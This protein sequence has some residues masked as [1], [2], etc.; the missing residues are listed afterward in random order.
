MKIEEISKEE[1][2]A[3]I[4]RAEHAV[5]HGLALEAE[6]VQLLIKALHSLLVL[7]SKIED[8]D[9][10]L[11]K[12]RKL[13]GIVNPNETRRT[14]SKSGDDKKTN[15]DKKRK[16]NNRNASDKNLPEIP[17]NPVEVEYHHIQ[18]LKKGDLCPQCSA[19]TLG[20]KSPLVFLRVTACAPY[21][22]TKHVIEQLQCIG[23]GFVVQAEVPAE[24][25]NDGDLGQ[26][27]GYTAR[28]TM[29]IKKYFSGSPYNHEA[30]LSQLMGCPISSS[31]IYDQNAKLAEMIKPV[32]EELVKESANCSLLHTDDTGNKILDEKGKMLPKRKG[33]GERWRTGVHT[34]GVIAM[35]DDGATIHLYYT[36]LGH[37][38]E[39]LDRI[40]SHRQTDLP[41]PLIA[42]DALSHNHPTVLEEF[43]LC[44]CNAH[45]RRQFIDLEELYPEEVLFVITR[46]DQIWQHEKSVKAEGLNTETRLAYHRQHS[47]P[48][49][50]EIRTWCLEKQGQSDYEKNGSFGKA[51]EYF[52]NHYVG[53]TQFCR[54]PGAPID[55]NIQEEALKVAIRSR[56]N[57]YFFKTQKG[58][59]VA[60][61]LTSV[62]TTAYRNGVNPFRYLVDLQRHQAEVLLDP[63]SW[64]PYHYAKR[65]QVQQDEA[66]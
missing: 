32:Y 49:M 20:A 5:E 9:I 52:L 38:G 8:R 11:R 37:S 53:L 56:K 22:A 43:V 1:L 39:N 44:L 54:I 61:I 31:T 48:I 42:C 41:P 65:Q 47:L 46:Y 4:Q 51:I 50:E 34:S 13:L 35:K 3:L 29:A 14:G 63:R 15:S 45:G 30:T 62:I 12:L 58:A 19:W 36:H 7:Q 60:N 2:Q 10:T 28:A 33:K 21:S 24:V 64:L 57:S 25:S 55:N 16:R 26:H 66:A 27:Y 40:L 59:D 18:D 17:V 6:D 23:C